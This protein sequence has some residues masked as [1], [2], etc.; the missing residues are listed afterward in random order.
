MCE[1]TAIGRVAMA[2]E[3]PSSREIRVTE[4]LTDDNGVPCAPP[5]T[6]VSPSGSRTADSA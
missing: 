1:A 3:L 4:P 6:S 2:E 5:M